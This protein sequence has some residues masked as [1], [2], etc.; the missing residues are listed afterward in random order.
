MF[1]QRPSL[2]AELYTPTNVIGAKRCASPAPHDADMRELQ[3]GES[4]R[5]L[6]SPTNVDGKSALPERKRVCRRP[7]LLF[8]PKPAPRERDTDDDLELITAAL[9][10]GAGGAPRPGLVVRAPAAGGSAACGG[11]DTPSL[12]VP[13][14]V[15]GSALEGLGVGMAAAPAGTVRVYNRETNEIEFVPVPSAPRGGSSR[16]K[17]GM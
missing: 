9:G 11:R 6:V 15:T 16:R 5:A 7:S 12:V 17:G 8:D 3:G 13:R 1:R 10:G 2:S 4:P 14:V